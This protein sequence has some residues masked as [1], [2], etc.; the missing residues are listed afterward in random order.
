[1]KTWLIHHYS[2]R[3]KYSLLERSVMEPFD[4]SIF[5]RFDME[6]GDIRILHSRI[7]QLTVQ[8]GEVQHMLIGH[9]TG[10]GVRILKEGTW[11]FSST[12]D[13]SFSGLANAVQRAHRTCLSYQGQA[14][15]ADV[16]PV[17]QM[18]KASRHSWA[19]DN[20]IEVA[21]K[22]ESAMHCSPHCKDGK[23][24]LRYTDT[25]KQFS[26]TDGTYIQQIL[27]LVVL[28]F[29][30]TAR[31]NGKVSESHFSCAF[32]NLKSLEEDELEEKALETAQEAIQG[33]DA[34]N[35]PN[36]QFPVILGSS[37]ASIFI[38]E[39]V[40]H[41][42]EADEVMKHHSLMKDKVDSLVAHPSLTVVDTMDGAQSWYGYDDEG[43]QKKET[44]LIDRGRV[45]GFLNDRQS[46][47][48]FD[49]DTTGN[50]RASNYNT[51]PLTRMTN[52]MALMGD[53]SF[54]EM[55]EECGQALFL[56]GFVGGA[57]MPDGAF[58]FVARRGY[59]IE[60][61]EFVSPVG[62]ST[63]SSSTLEALSHISGV[64]KKVTMHY[65][66][67]IKKGQG[68]MVGLGSPALLVSQLRVGG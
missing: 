63:I 36:G 40:G 12:T 49:T 54:E 14:C 21:R 7:Q 4:P 31:R 53:M 42:M 10:A 30:A 45:Q 1:M 47:H 39:A 6:Y 9:E 27:P 66:E 8:N 22:L 33:L 15:L 50:S 24:L 5:S 55:I 67:C 48:Y 16:R 13:I 2:A 3:I 43:V 18:G 25:I 65:S 46:A 58:R 17:K 60:R 34:G 20:L 11:G 44:V 41:R 62:K 51:I 57:A 56:D 59:F 35:T 52:I 28:D 26:S 64:G 29:W 32:M 68:L 38:H 23:V 61:G 19:D 37:L